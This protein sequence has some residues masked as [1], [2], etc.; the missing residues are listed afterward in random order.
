MKNN[1]FESTE[2]EDFS[3]NSIEFYQKQTDKSNE[4]EKCKRYD[5]L[6]ISSNIFNLKKNLE[7]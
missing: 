2:R 4:K 1:V 6:I 5:A 3:Q 7:L